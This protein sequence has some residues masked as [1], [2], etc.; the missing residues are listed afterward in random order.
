MGELIRELRPDALVVVGTDHGR[1]HPLSSM[2]QYLIG[3]SEQAVGIGDAGLPEKTLPLQGA[4]L[5][6]DAGHG[7][8]RYSKSYT[9]GTRGWKKLGWP[10]RIVNE[11]VS[12]LSF[13]R[14]SP[15]AAK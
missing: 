13:T 11:A 3:V 6:V 8:Q 12:W 10:V 5:V 14:A 15:S 9:G 7:G 4:V 2:P 1:I